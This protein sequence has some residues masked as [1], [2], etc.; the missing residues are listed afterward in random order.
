MVVHQFFDSSSIYAFI[1]FYCPI[2]ASTP[3]YNLTLQFV[4]I[5]VPFFAMLRGICATDRVVQHRIKTLIKPMSE[6]YLELY[7]SAMEIREFFGLRDF[8]RY[9]SQL[10]TI[11]KFKRSS[12]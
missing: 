1:W 12:R 3:L 6:A 7:N 4:F 8:Y 9:A 11:C 5:Y 2:S 10:Q